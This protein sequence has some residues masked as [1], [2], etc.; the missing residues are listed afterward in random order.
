MRNHDKIN[1]NSQ[2]SSFSHRSKSLFSS[3]FFPPARPRSIV[4]FL[5]RLE[6]AP[7][8]AISTLACSNIGTQSAA[9]R[10]GAVAVSVS[11]KYDAPADPAAGASSSTDKRQPF[12]FLMPTHSSA[13]TASRQQ[14]QPDRYVQQDTPT[15]HESKLMVRATG[16][17]AVARNMQPFQPCRSTKTKNSR[18]DVN[19]RKKRRANAPLQTGQFTGQFTDRRRT[20]TDVAAA[21]PQLEVQL[22]G[23]SAAKKS[24]VIYSLFL[25]YS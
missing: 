10:P 15:I 25:R 6:I 20:S 24:A 16:S 14:T 21:A 9:L 7:C 23:T 1:I 11:T 18:R 3:K 13:N 5:A 17:S 22:V 12:L 4:P 2:I 8:S 19:A